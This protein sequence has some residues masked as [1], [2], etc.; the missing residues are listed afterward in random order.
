MNTVALQEYTLPHT[1]NLSHTG[2]KVLDILT[3]VHSARSQVPL[4]ITQ[5]L[6]LDIL[7]LEPHITDI[8][9]AGNIYLL[10]K[11]KR[12]KKLDISKFLNNYR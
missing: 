2:Q 12:G 7:S 9:E 5:K 11:K 1:S 10:Y 3:A 4:Q 8:D 6:V